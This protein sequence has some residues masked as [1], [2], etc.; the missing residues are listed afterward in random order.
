[1]LMIVRIRKHHNKQNTHN[2]VHSAYYYAYSEHN[3]K[4][5]NHNKIHSAYDCAYY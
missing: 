4:H 5:N 3:N 2:N 1:M